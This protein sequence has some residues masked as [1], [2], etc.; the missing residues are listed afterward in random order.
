M[1]IH[2]A[3]EAGLIGSAIENE[4]RTDQKN[5]NNVGVF[6]HNHKEI[7]ELEI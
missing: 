3:I 2:C 6:C 5:K 4:P 1:H 7:A